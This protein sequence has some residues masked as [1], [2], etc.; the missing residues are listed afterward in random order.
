MTPTF[1]EIYPNALSDELC[2]ELIN[3]GNELI[4]SKHEGVDFNENS[5]R[6]DQN[7]FINS[8]SRFDT[9]RESIEKVIHKHMQDYCEKYDVNYRN[10]LLDRSLKFQ[11]S[12]AGQGFYTWHSEQGT[13]D[14]YSGRFA[15]WMFYLNDVTEGGATQFKHFDLDV[16]PTKGTL[17]L[18]PA[19]YTHL[20][21]AA[22]DLEQDKYI[23]TGWFS[24]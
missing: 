23:L 9:Q 11:K 15:V 22:P 21:R 2:D 14:Q 6:V 16:Q 13:G 3:M 1:I 8:Y 4:E 7:I 24:L 5:N 17:V 20:H 18:W 12:S 10:E 19:A